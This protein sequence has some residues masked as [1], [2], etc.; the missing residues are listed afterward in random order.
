MNARCQLQQ[1]LIVTQ[2]DKLAGSSQKAHKPSSDNQADSLA[3]TCVFPL[4]TGFEPLPFC[5][6]MSANVSTQHCT[7]TATVRRG[8][9]SSHARLPSREQCEATDDESAHPVA[10]CIYSALRVRNKVVEKLLFRHPRHLQRFNDHAP[11]KWELVSPAHLAG[12]GCCGRT[13]TSTFE[14][15]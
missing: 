4:V 8:I 5:I 11:S 14:R 10:R 6:E 3:K 15:F 1:K 2:P 12:T 7:R 13:F 9:R